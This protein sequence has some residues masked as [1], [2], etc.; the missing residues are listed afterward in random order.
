MKLRMTTTS[1]LNSNE[2]VRYT[3]T[4]KIT[5]RETALNRIYKKV[6]ITTSLAIPSK[7]ILATSLTIATNQ[8]T[9]IMAL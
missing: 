7:K 6:L 2:D 5:N 1:Y 8:M 4:H 3:D 9:I